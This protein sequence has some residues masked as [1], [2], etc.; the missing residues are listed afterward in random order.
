MAS[1]AKCTRLVKRLATASATNAVMTTVT[2]YSLSSCDERTRPRRRTARLDEIAR[3]PPNAEALA[4][5]SCAEDWSSVLAIC[6]LM[7]RG[8]RAAGGGGRRENR[9]ENQRGSERGGGRGREGARER[10]RER[11]TQNAVMT[12]IQHF[13]E[14]V[15]CQS[16]WGLPIG[17]LRQTVPCQELECFPRRRH[18]SPLS[19]LRKQHVGVR[20]DIY[21]RQKPGQSR[22]HVSDSSL[23][24]RVR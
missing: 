14:R 16:V 23:Q 21:R 12:I 18:K 10:E 9:K 5:L 17:S 11:G 8:K 22:A 24:S 2:K 20:P 4:T 7:E 19:P 6:G 15:F 3:I 13:R 1:I